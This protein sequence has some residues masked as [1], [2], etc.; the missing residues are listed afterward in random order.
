M[1]PVRIMSI[2]GKKGKFY[3]LLFQ[4]DVRERDQRF[5]SNFTGTSMLR[6]PHGP[7][8]GLEKSFFSLFRELICGSSTLK[9]LIDKP[10]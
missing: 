9:S 10:E 4:E 1:S 2:E 3:W 6:G 7:A 8:P 5:G